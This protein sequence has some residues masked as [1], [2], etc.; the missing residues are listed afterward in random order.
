MS[1]ANK[2]KPGPSLQT[3]NQ[4]GQASSQSGFPRLATSGKQ[5]QENQ[6]STPKLHQNSSRLGNVPN[7]PSVLDVPPSLAIS[8]RHRDNDRMTS[9]LKELIETTRT[10]ADNFLNSDEL[11]YPIHANTTSQRPH[12]VDPANQNINKPSSKASSSKTQSKNKT[13]V[14]SDE[15]KTPLLKRSTFTAHRLLYST[16][17]QMDQESR[18]ITIGPL[19][20]EWVVPAR[21]N[22]KRRYQA[23]KSMV[24]AKRAWSNYTSN[25]RT[26]IEIFNDDIL[27]EVSEGNSST[28]ASE[29]EPSHNNNVSNLDFNDLHVQSAFNIPNDVNNDES[30]DDLSVKIFHGPNDDILAPHL[31]SQSSRAHASVKWG[32]I[33]NSSKAASMISSEFGNLS[34]ESRVRDRDRIRERR[35][36]TFAQLLADDTLQP[37]APVFSNGSAQDCLSDNTSTEGNRDYN[38]SAQYSNDSDFETNSLN[39]VSSNSTDNSDP[40]LKTHP[41]PK[42]IL[43]GVSKGE[44]SKTLRGIFGKSGE[45]DTNEN[46]TQNRDSNNNASMYLN[47]IRNK[48]D[49]QPPKPSGSFIPEIH[50]SHTESLHQSPSTNHSTHSLAMSHDFSQSSVITP[51]ELSTS[52]SSVAPSFVTAQGSAME[53][54]YNN[55]DDSSIL[56]TTS[57]SNSAR[58]DIISPSSQISTFSSSAFQAPA[59]STDSFTTAR[60]G[61]TLNSSTYSAFDHF[62]SQSNSATYASSSSTPKV[63]GEPTT[64]ASSQLVERNI[65]DHDCAGSLVST[66]RHQNKQ[67]VGSD[68]ASINTIENRQPDLQNN[69]DSPLSPRTEAKVVWKLPTSAQRNMSPEAPK[70]SQAKN[71]LQETDSAISE[72]SDVSRKPSVF[73]EISRL[74][75]HAEQVNK[76]KNLSIK[77]H[78]NQ[79]PLTTSNIA[80]PQTVVEDFFN[81]HKFLSTKETGEA[82]RFEHILV[83]IKATSS[84]TYVPPNF[85]EFE[86]IDTRILERWKEYIVVVRKTDSFDEPLVVQFYS[87]RHI[88][89]VEPDLKP[90]SKYDFRISKNMVIKFYST[91]DKTVA[92]WKNDTLNSLKDKKK[93]R[94]TKIYIFQGRTHYDSI[95][96]YAFLAKCL[97]VVQ[98]TSVLVSVPDLSL[99][100]EIVM[101]WKTLF[102]FH[103]ERMMVLGLDE[104]L[105]YSELKSF[106]VRGSPAVV[107]ILA[108]IL[109]KLMAIDVV[110][111]DFENLLISHKVG[112]AWRRYDRLEW[113]RELLDEAIYSGWV[114]NNSHDLELRPKAPYPSQVTFEDQ[115]RMDEPVPIEGFLIR[116]SRWNGKMSVK[117]KRDYIQWIKYQQQRQQQEGGD[118]HSNT[119]EPP[120]FNSIDALFYKKL[121]FHTHDNL[122]FFSK[123]QRAVPPAPPSIVKSDWV[124]DE[125][126]DESSTHSEIPTGPIEVPLVYETRPYKNDEDEEI[127][128]LNDSKSTALEAET[129]DRAASY[130]MH[131]RTSMIV[132]A[133][134]FIDLC[135]IDIVR[136]VKRDDYNIDGK[137]GKANPTFFNWLFCYNDDGNDDSPPDISDDGIVT[138]FDDDTVFEIVMLSG[139]VIRLQAFNMYTRDLWIKSLSELSRYWKRRIYEDVAL[140]NIVRQANL[141]QLHIDEGYEPFVGEASPK[142]ET[143]SGIAHPSIFH[144]SRI[145]WARAISIHGILYQKPNKHSTF[146]RYYVVLTHGHLMM[147]SVYHRTFMGDAKHRADHRRFQAISLENCYVYSGSATQTELLQKDRWFDREHPG[148]HSIPRVY[149]DGW[150]SAEE[151]SHRCF[152]LWF[153]NKRPIVD[154]DSHSVA[155]NRVLRKKRSQH[156]KRMNPLSRSAETNQTLRVHTHGSEDAGAQGGDEQGQDDRSESMFGILPDLDGTNRVKMANRLGVTG[157]SMVF[158][159]RSRQERDM[160][161]LALNTE[162]DRTVKSSTQDIFIL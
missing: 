133:D 47:L 44:A 6:T 91:L 64:P 132:G 60:G 50:D 19:P 109:K 25:K 24:S 23:M 93:D 10:E 15:C 54:P 46:G 33:S 67:E 45:N 17:K 51:S 153:A 131:R 107:Y 138:G 154:K 8:S 127:E 28:N 134:G 2:S 145:A 61:S 9:K 13:E 90:V 94:F 87:S 40:Q 128:W 20:R 18:V 96:F 32:D 37:I 5:S 31:S 57:A 105:T 119:F 59:S 121:Y 1:S 11:H 162:I 158:M 3:I 137:L 70:R 135:E 77:N 88:K 52:S 66:I 146:R 113:V 30:N 49:F 22:W 62:H 21:N 16:P 140:L 71:I 122:L 76:A 112:L 114:L 26:D 74:K 155:L 157:I 43:I 35:N 142:W 129:Q 34:S 41:Q 4:R 106:L 156:L 79:Q 27:Q 7:I 14:S 69:T 115:T 72:R 116:L 124:M 141:E 117:Q 148:S 100:L 161:V 139:I 85:N 123:P 36:S 143:N 42:P 86:T 84:G 89:I 101:P 56:S 55:F 149:P 53:G 92:V 75:V 29:P 83:M 98:P 104:K 118:S 103:I 12:E 110:R 126:L 80:E 152:V 48:Y 151:E 120:S 159:A 111:D 99:K 102:K 82:I 108:S 58:S 97:G 136:K 73:E 130:E 160:W 39:S 147:Y 150:K 144:I 95:K 68:D 63:P 81:L 125:D 65:V 38:R 78:P